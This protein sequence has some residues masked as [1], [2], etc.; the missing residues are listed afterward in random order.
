MSIQ[1]TFENQALYPVRDI[2]ATDCTTP[3]DTPLT[4]EA[5]GDW[6]RLT[7]HRDSDVILFPGTDTEH[8]IGGFRLTRQRFEHPHEVCLYR[9]PNAYN[10]TDTDSQLGLW[11]IHWNG[12]NFQLGSG[13]LD[14]LGFYTPSL[15]DARRIVATLLTNIARADAKQSDWKDAVVSVVD[16]L[17]LM[18]IQDYQRTHASGREK[19]TP[20]CEE[21]AQIHSNARLE[22]RNISE[23]RERIFEELKQEVAA[24]EDRGFRQMTVLPPTFDDEQTLKQQYANG[25][26][27]LEELE[28]ALERR[29]QNEPLVPFDDYLDN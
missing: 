16:R 11:F 9:L 6:T 26:L 22:W 2:T 17:N 5:D 13:G 25:N 27:S 1:T 14:A 19:H 28:E 23:Y 18:S 7:D 20:W 3:I 29:W 21:R 4:T 10:H 15:R 24:D 8:W 12:A